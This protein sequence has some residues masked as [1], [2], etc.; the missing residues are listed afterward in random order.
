MGYDTIDSKEF[1]PLLDSVN[2]YGKPCFNQAYACGMGQILNLLKEYKD[3]GVAK[4]NVEFLHLII[5]SE[6]DV[7]DKSITEMDLRIL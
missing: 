5:A 2:P 4:R 7:D 1:K 3:E 6:Y